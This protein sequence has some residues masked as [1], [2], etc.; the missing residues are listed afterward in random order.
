MCIFGGASTPSVPAPP[1]VVDTT[2]IASQTSAAQAASNVQTKA[3]LAN[4]LSSTIATSPLGVTTPATTVAKT[5]LLGG[6]AT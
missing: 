5:S 1:P 4:G 2:S 3:A 6:G